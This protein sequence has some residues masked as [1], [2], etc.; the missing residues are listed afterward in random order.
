MPT[1]IDL[2]LAMYLISA[3]PSIYLIFM[4]ALHIQQKANAEFTVEKHKEALEKWHMLWLGIMTCVEIVAGLALFVL[5]IGATTSIGDG[6]GTN[7]TCY[8]AEQEMLKYSS[9]ARISIKDLPLALAILSV[10]Y[11]LWYILFLVNEVSKFL[12]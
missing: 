4:V 6:W 7:T 1:Y 2:R 3:V 8:R 5:D 11:M 12:R 9:G 10:P